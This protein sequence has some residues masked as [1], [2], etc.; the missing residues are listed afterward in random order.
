MAEMWKPKNAEILKSWVKALMESPSEEL[1]DWEKKFVSDMHIRLS[2][3]SI[4][5]EFQEN[6]LEEI[7]AEKTS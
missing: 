6:K 4:L 2:L 3:G 5:T 1:T 7:Y